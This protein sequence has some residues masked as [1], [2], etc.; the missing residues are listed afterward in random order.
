[1]RYSKWYSNQDKKL[2]LLI[3][4][5]EIKDQFRLP[6]PTNSKHQQNP[7]SAG[8]VVSGGWKPQPADLR[9]VPSRCRAVGALFPLHRHD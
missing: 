7:P 9:I 2:V 8:F 4:I 6:R 5:K 3:I 1:M